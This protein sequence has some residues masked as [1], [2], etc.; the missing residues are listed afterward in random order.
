MPS[1]DVKIFCAL[2]VS[3]VYTVDYV[4]KMKE[5]M[6][7][8]AP[9]VPFIC[10]SNTALS[11]IQTIPMKH[12]WP[13]WWCKMEMFHPKIEGDIFFVDLD[14]FILDN[15]EDFLKVRDLT[16][17]TDFY[18]PEGLG[19]GLMYIP[20]SARADVWNSFVRSP[21]NN[22]HNFK[23]GGDQRFLMSVWK[24]KPQRWQ[25]VLPN[26]VVSYKAQRIKDKGV[27]DNTGILCFHGVPK[28]SDL[29]WQLPGMNYRNGEWVRL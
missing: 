27:P 10:I 5:Q 28:P 7:V 24:N 21:V 6:D 9:N 29:N 25:E 3:S 23:I 1:R 13:G 15:I 19:S 14:T 22:M 2:R 18:K 11:G 8:Y 26:R 4:Y 17:L 16:M 20:Q 12:M